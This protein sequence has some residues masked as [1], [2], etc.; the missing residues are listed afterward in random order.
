MADE[1]QWWLE[2]HALPIFV[3]LGAALA[4]V[5]FMAFRGPAGGGD[6]VDLNEDQ[7]L[8]YDRAATA[9]LSDAQS[10]LD[11][12]AAAHGGSYEGAT[13]AD[14]DASIQEDADITGVE[15][16]AVADTDSITLTSGSGGVFTISRSGGQLTY[17]CSSPG[18]GACGEESTWVPDT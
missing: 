13:V 7:I 4:V 16:D 14:I 10:A 2:D 17:T 3:V 8:T 15:V 1:V 12:Y 18:L 5:A 6:S 11:S 9:S